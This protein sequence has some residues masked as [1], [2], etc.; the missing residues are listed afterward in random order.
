MKAEAAEIME[1]KAAANPAA[2]VK[3]DTETPKGTLAI[4]LGFAAILVALWGFMYI[5]MLLRG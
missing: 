1:T 5:T 3:A 4:L 2:D